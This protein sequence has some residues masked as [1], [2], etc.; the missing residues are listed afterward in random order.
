MKWTGFV[1]P[2]NVGPFTRKLYEFAAEDPSLGKPVFYSRSSLVAPDEVIVQLTFGSKFFL[3]RASHKKLISAQEDAAEVAVEEVTRMVSAK[4]KGQRR[5]SDARLQIRPSSEVL[6]SVVQTAEPDM[7][8]TNARVAGMIG[9]RDDETRAL[10]QSSSQAASSYIP[11]NASSRVPAPSRL[12]DQ[13]SLP[14]AP[15][16][17][18]PKIPIKG[19]RRAPK[20]TALDPEHRMLKREEDPAWDWLDDNTW[21]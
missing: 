10:T 16:Q 17:I 5:L 3:S 9:A 2:D 11:S 14:R 4:R 19:K 20:A 1:I 18:P 21:T 8:N 13:V 7:V 12:P 15:S 6:A